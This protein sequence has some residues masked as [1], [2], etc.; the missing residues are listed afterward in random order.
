MRAFEKKKMT[1][2]ESEVES[3]HKCLEKEKKTKIKE[4][5][6]KGDVLILNVLLLKLESFSKLHSMS[7][8]IAFIALHDTFEFEIAQQSVDNAGF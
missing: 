1:A 8:H 7:C 5:I 4:K 2:L 6:E 3:E